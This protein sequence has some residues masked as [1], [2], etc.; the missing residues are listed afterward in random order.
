MLQ[1]RILTLIKS[2]ITFLRS[3]DVPSV[4]YPHSSRFWP[5]LWCG[6]FAASPQRRSVSDGLD[7][8]VHNGYLGVDLQ[9]LLL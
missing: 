7:V 6:T 1:H 2:E 8:V 3:P 9:Q 4:T 5:L